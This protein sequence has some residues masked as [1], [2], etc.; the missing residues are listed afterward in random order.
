LSAKDITATSMQF[1]WTAPFHNGGGT[2]DG[3]ILTYS[4]PVFEEKQSVGNHL[5]TVS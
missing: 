4:E 1:Q 3:Y 5:R 2:L